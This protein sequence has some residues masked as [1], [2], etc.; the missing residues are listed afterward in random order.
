MNE[1][2]ITNMI[3]LICVCHTS[4]P[5]SPPLCLQFYAVMCAVYVLYGLGWLVV[6]GRQWRELLRIQFWIGGVIAM[7]MLEKVRDR[8]RTDRLSVQAL[9]LSMQALVL[10]NM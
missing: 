3:D 8:R 6:C 2:K 5:P 7:G 10:L 1:K 9:R 4:L